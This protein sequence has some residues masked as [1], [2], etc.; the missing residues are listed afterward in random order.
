MA[1]DSAHQRRQ[2]VG[3]EQG[4][5]EDDQRLAHRIGVLRDQQ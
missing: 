4:A 2:Q 3:K 5:N 1:L